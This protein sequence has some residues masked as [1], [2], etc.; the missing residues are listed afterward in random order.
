M[1]PVT[2]RYRLEFGDY[3]AL[4]LYL[5]RASR[6]HRL[7]ALAARVWPAA[8]ILALLALEGHQQAAWFD[9]WDLL[10]ACLGAAAWCMAVPAVL[11]WRLK[12]QLRAYAA[13]NPEAFRI[14]PVE[15]RFGPQGIVS[16]TARGGVPLAWGAVARV[17]ETN[18]HLFIFVE[19]ADSLIIPKRGPADHARVDAVRTMIA[20]NA[21]RA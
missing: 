1:A 9:N 3:L 20:Q 12:Q 21:A 10:I 18:E 2:L 19:D 14:G 17:A 5:L 4:S 16:D 11:K 15:T 13:T 7:V 6:S 8:A